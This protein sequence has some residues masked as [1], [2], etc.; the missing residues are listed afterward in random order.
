M[1]QAEMGATLPCRPGLGPGRRGCPLASRLR[2]RQCSPAR[3]TAPTAS[4][5]TDAVPLDP[6]APDGPPD[7]EVP[8]RGRAPAAAAASGLGAGRSAAAESHDGSATCVSCGTPLSGPFCAGC[9]ER[10]LRPDEFSV[11]RLLSEG[12]RDALGADSRLW[13]TLKRLVVRPGALTVDYMTGR[14]AGVLGPVQ[15][16]LLCNLIYFVLQPYSGFTGY[17]TPLDSHVNR[18]VYSGTMVRDRVRE[19]M[20]DG[21]DERTA[22][23]ISRARSD[24]EVVTPTDSISIR[25]TAREIELAL[26]PSRFNDTGAVLARTLVALI[27]P[28]LVAAL[29]VLFVGRGVPLVQHVVF[30]THLH[31]WELFLV[32]SVFLPL[33]TY[34]SLGVLGVVGAVTGRS[35]AEVA[36]TD[37][38]SLVGNLVLEFG[39]Y[40]L[41]LVYVFIALRRA[42]GGGLLATSVRTVLLTAATQL[43]TFLYRFILFWATWLAVR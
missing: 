35:T 8:P 26:Y 21:V 16:F 32:S 1:F 36:A 31:A 12:L 40:P 34:A 17:N 7:E 4:P 41:V 23:E 30:A 25:A 18:Q 5:P 43:S 9:G 20:E 28:M 13:R 38:W 33:L 10:R 2:V 42:Y 6:T 24:G 15:L 11:R 37:T 19:A 29:L 3:P 14:R 22:L 27:I 39:A